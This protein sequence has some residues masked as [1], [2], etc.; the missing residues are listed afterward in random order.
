MSAFMS[1]FVQTGLLA[2]MFLFF[3]IIFLSGQSVQESLKVK[4]QPLCVYIQSSFVGFT[5][6]HYLFLKNT[7]K[8]QNNSVQKFCTD[9]WELSFSDYF[10]H[11]HKEWEVL[12]LSVFYWTATGLKQKKKMQAVFRISKPSLQYSR[13]LS[14]CKTEA[15]GTDMQS[16]HSHTSAVHTRIKRQL[17]LSL[18]V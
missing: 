17:K 8:K 6:T 14:S 4:Y 9:I 10:C 2:G 13:C 7:N 18:P 12:Q 3:I 15:A 5:C 11:W 1:S 16:A